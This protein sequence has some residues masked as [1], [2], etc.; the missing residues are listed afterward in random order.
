MHLVKAFTQLHVR[1]IRNGYIL[2]DTLAMPGL[3]LSGVEMTC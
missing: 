2:R 1:K 3:S